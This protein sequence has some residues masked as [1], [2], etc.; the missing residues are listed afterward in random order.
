MIRLVFSFLTLTIGARAGTPEAMSLLKTNCL[1]CHNP[2]KK[3]GKLDLTT[4]EALLLGGENGKVAV[5]G[6]SA[7]SRLIH[8]LQAGAD[9]HMPPKGQLSPRAIATF[10]AWIDEGIEWDAEALKVRPSPKHEELENLP[11]GFSPVL[12][13]ALASDGK[14]LAAGRGNK[15]VVFDLSQGNKVVATLKGHRDA[16][17]SLAWSSDGKWLASGGY[18]SAR[19]WNGKWQSVREIRALEGQVTALA[20]APDDKSLF[21]AESIPTRRGMVHRWGLAE[22]RKFAE[23]VAHKDSVFGLAVSGDGKQI[24]TA[25]GDRVAKVWDLVTGKETVNIEGHDTAIYGLAFNKDGTQLTTV[26]ADREL[27][28]WD[29]KTK[30]RLTSLQ[31]NRGVKIHKGSVTAVRWTPDDTK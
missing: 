11:E 5:P 18:R 3:K 13:I 4:R 10:E 12:A 16:V 19:I 20:F 15:V 24:A 9:P 29:L 31:N 2:E 23:W 22:G 30:L 26:S 7:V 25:G 27:I 8:G 1:S 17:R 28:I 14:R 21:T 6:K